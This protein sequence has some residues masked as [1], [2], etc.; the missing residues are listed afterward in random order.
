MLAVGKRQ[1][2]RFALNPETSLSNI[3]GMRHKVV[4]VA[5]GSP[6]GRSRPF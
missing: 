3:T 2:G 6:H 4:F 1:R 5:I